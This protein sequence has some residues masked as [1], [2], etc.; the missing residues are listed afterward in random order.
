MT[1]AERKLVKEALR[2]SAREDSVNSVWRAQNEEMPFE[3]SVE[4]W[5]FDYGSAVVSEGDITTT[6]KGNLPAKLKR[7]LKKIVE[8]YGALDKL[9]G[10]DLEH[11]ASRR[12]NLLDIGRGNYAAALDSVGDYGSLTE[13]LWGHW[14]NVQDTAVEQGY[15]AEEVR[16]AMGAF[17]ACAI[18]DGRGDWQEE[19]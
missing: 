3:E 10:P 1:N 4:S 17:D 9:L 18:D 2:L 19:Y 7:R 16:L 5:Y 12:E 6:P 13:S 8:L 15:S 11:V 14:D